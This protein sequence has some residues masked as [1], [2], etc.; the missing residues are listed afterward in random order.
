MLVGTQPRD[1][2]KR[3]TDGWEDFFTRL[4]AEQRR[5]RQSPEESSCK[6]AANEECNWHECCL[7]VQIFQMERSL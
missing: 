7:G 4:E 6:A 5:E 2:G 1:D 3:R